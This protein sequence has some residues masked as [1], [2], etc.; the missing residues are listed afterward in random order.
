MAIGRSLVLALLSCPAA[1]TRPRS[2]PSLPRSSAPGAARAAP[3][4][5]AV[6]AGLVDGR[7]RAAVSAGA[8]ALHPVGPLH[9]PGGGGDAADGDKAVAVGSTAGRRTPPALLATPDAAPPPLES[10]PQWPWVFGPFLPDVAGGAEGSG[11]GT[12]PP[13]GPKMPTHGS[14]RGGGG[15]P[16]PHALLAALVALFLL[17]A[18]FALQRGAR[19][20]EEGGMAPSSSGLPSTPG[21]RRGQ[22]F[23]ALVA[24]AALV[25]AAAFLLQLV[26]VPGYAAA[27][28]PSCGRALSSTFLLVAIFATGRGATAGG[29]AHVALLSLG[30]WAQLQAARSAAQAVLRWGLLV[31]GLASGWAAA[32]AVN[33]VIDHGEHLENKEDR[34]EVALD[35]LCACTLVQVLLGLCEDEVFGP[36]TRLM[37]GGSLDVFRVFAVGRLLLKRTAALDEAFTAERAPATA[38]C[39][40]L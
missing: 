31:C 5:Q 34:V 32:S 1:G 27:P 21:S 40:Q 3:A 20:V 9:A 29:A 14:V 8:G 2:A 10:E 30:A 28:W 33:E 18:A 37:L 11:S 16:T 4:E 19:F 38:A 17:G 26:A 24:A 35:L 23:H 6:A 25:E 7:N 15:S 39:A 22:R 36:S 13:P 12:S